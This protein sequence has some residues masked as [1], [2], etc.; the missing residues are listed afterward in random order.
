[1]PPA[2]RLARTGAAASVAILLSGCVWPF[3]PF[4]GVNPGLGPSADGSLV[5]RNDTTEDWIVAIGTDVPIGYA[6]PAGVTGTAELWGSDPTQ[7]ALLDRDCTE[8][9]RLDLDEAPPA[10]VIGE[11]GA[12]SA[13]AV[14]P[15]TA[16]Q[17]LVEY[18]ECSFGFGSVEAGEALPAAA[19]TLD[20]LGEDGGLWSIVPSD[21]TLTNV[22]DGSVD[23]LAGEFAWSPDGTTLAFSRYDEMS[24]TA[25]IYLTDADG[26]NE[27]LLVED[28][29]SPT[30]SPDGA[31]IAYVDGDPFSGSALTVVAVAGGEPTVLATDAY[32]PRWAPSGERIAF[33]DGAAS[34]FETEELVDLRVVD[35]TS[36]EEATV[37]QVS[38]YTPPPAWSPDG[39]RIAFLAGTFDAPTVHVVSLETDQ[40]VTLADS[41][42]AMYGEPSWSPDG[43]RLA[44]SSTTYGFITASGGLVLLDA[45]GA[46]AAETLVESDR[47]TYM[48]P[49]WSPDG[50]WIAAV[51]WAETGG[52][53]LVVVSAETGE[54]T[55]VATGV[56]AILGWRP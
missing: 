21:A 42:D 8:V 11:S 56:S 43:E 29:F 17:V 10:V 36:G 30:W 32:L 3:P 13:E 31:R 34:G 20:L 9:D 5:V 47:S 37:A 15:S 38:S 28:G 7:V 14:E 6:V 54:Q 53:E 49:I 48:S 2:R 24:T 51:H 16:D 27:R 35:A 39:T 41:G 50:Q 55:V 4:F 40:T 45:S 44:A 12:L 22:M 33:L 18:L 23:M 26:S 19:G 52:A 1:M 46:D 25:A